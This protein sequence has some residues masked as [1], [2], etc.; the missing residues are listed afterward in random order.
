MADNLVI[1][2][3]KVSNLTNAKSEPK[4]STLKLT[5]ACSRLCVGRFRMAI[6]PIPIHQKP[7]IDQ[8]FPWSFT[9]ESA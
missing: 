8:S 9:S 1:H 2:Q 3:T 5:C 7:Y 4:V 6:L